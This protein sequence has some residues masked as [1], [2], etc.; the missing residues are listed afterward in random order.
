MRDQAGGA[1][2]D[3]HALQPAEREADAEQHGGNRGRDIELQVLADGG[4]DGG[5]DRFGDVHEALAAAGRARDLEQFRHARI[6]RLVLRVAVAGD[7]RA[8]GVQALHRGL[9]GGGEIAV[10]SGCGIDLREE[11]ARRFRRAEDHR[12]A[13]EDAGGDGALHRIG[14]RGERHA[15]GLHARH[16]AV[17]GDGHQGRIEHRAG[18]R[19]R[20]AAGEQQEK[21]VR[22]ANLPD[23]LA[24]QVA[25]AHDDA[26]G[27]RGADR[28]ARD[29]RLADLHAATVVAAVTAT[30]ATV[31]TSLKSKLALCHVW[32]MVRPSGAVPGAWRA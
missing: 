15:R 7:G 4:R 25:P 6:A 32:V 24:G 8:V 26:F 18:R 16:E 28:R 17:L 1:R 13:A 23:Q 20:H 3:G 12:A 22:E 30:G 21:I 27:I 31:G 2:E 29:G 10:G 14:R 19:I 11:P 5:L 9:R